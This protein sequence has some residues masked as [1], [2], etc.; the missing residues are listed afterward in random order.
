MKYIKRIRLIKYAY[1]TLTITY[2]TSAFAYN[3]YDC[4]NDVASIDSEI[5]IGLATELCSAAWSSEPAK[6]Y[7]GISKIDKEIPRGIAIEL[8]AGSVNAEKTLECYA[9]GGERQLNRGLAT[10]LCGANKIKN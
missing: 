9:K 4:L 10:T 2:C 6:C 1:F 5:P 3:P 7:L 8:C